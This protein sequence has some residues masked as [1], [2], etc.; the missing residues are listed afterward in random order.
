MTLFEECIFALDGH[1]FIMDEKK[2]Q[3]Y[4]RR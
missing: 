4:L 3:K 2:T 1:V